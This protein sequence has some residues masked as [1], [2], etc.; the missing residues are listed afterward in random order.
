MDTQNTNTQPGQESK[1]DSILRLEQIIK[2]YLFSLEQLQEDV[3]MQSAML[4]DL[5]ENDKTYKEHAEKAKAAIKQRNFT[6]MEIMKQS[7]GSAILNKIKDLKDEMKTT[8]TALSDYLIEY[9]KTSGLNQIT[10]SEGKILEIVY[11]TKLVR[12]SGKD[13]P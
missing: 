8:R 6:K 2:K 1:V 3:R 4:S 7:Q 10:D 11:S 9:N 5:F 13:K 12:K